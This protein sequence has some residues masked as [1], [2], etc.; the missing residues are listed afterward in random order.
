M[1][2][3]SL[4]F[5]KS[6]VYSTQPQNFEELEQKIRA[7]CGLVTPDLWQSVGQECIKRWLKCLKIGGS[8]VE[9]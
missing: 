2:L 9:V 6:K 8:H 4:G 1:L 5:L 7:L 3:F